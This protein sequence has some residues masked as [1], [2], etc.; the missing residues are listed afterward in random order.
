MFNPRIRQTAYGLGTIA[1]TVVT[2]LA[3]WHGI[4]G[5]TAT[6]LGN[7]ITAILGLLGVGA[8]ATAGVVVS[9]QRKEG[10]LDF[11]G[12]PEQQAV[13]AINAV[14]AQAQAA[15][16]ALDKVKAAASD[17]LSTIPVFGPLAKQVIDSVKLP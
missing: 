1:T 14:S 8:T 3:L 15:T 16:A 12:S 9:K 7:A 11:S 10:T 6:A 2:I 17:V 4:D 13:D 5:G